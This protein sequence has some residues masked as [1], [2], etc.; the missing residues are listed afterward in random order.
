V[1]LLYLNPAISMLKMQGINGAD[2]FAYFKTLIT[3]K[4]CQNCQSLRAKK[5]KNTLP[6]IGE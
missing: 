5:M 3:K 2:V 4:I 1:N 6:L